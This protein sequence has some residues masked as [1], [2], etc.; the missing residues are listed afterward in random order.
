MQEFYIAREG[1]AYGP[2]TFDDTNR[3]FLEGSIDRETLVWEPSESNWIFAENH[4]S[5]S[6]IF[7]RNVFPEN[8]V[9]SQVIVISNQGEIEKKANE[10]AIEEEKISEIRKEIELLEC[11]HKEMSS[12][13]EDLRI[14]SAQ[15]NTELD[16]LVKKRNELSSELEE[17][18]REIEKNR[19]ELSK[20]KPLMEELESIRSEKKNLEEDISKTSKELE[21]KLIECAGC[22]AEISLVRDRLEAI[23]SETKELEARRIE[24]EAILGRQVSEGFE[25]IKNSCSEFDRITGKWNEAGERDEELRKTGLSAISELRETLA[26]R[27][28]ELNGMIASLREQSIGEIEYQSLKRQADEEEKRLERF[29]DE[30]KNLT[31]LCFEESQRLEDYKKEREEVKTDIDAEFTR[32][33]ELELNLKQLQ[34][35]AETV[36]GSLGRL[37]FE[38][39]QLET[40]VSALKKEKEICEE[41]VEELRRARSEIIESNLKIESEVSVS[42]SRKAELE[43]TIL[44]YELALDSVVKKIEAMK[45]EREAMRIA[46][47][48]DAIKAR[49]FTAENDTMRKAAIEA[50]KEVELELDSSFEELARM[51]DELEKLQSENSRLKEELNSS[52]IE[53]AR[54]TEERKIEEERF[55]S[56]QKRKTELIKE[57]DLL[58]SELD[59]IRGETASLNENVISLNAKKAGLEERISALEKDE[60]L[61]QTGIA[62]ME[63][64]IKSLDSAR[65][66]LEKERA[67]LARVE[68]RELRELLIA[69]EQDEKDKLEKLLNEARTEFRLLKE[70]WSKEERLGVTNEELKQLRDEVEQKRSELVKAERQLSA[71]RAGLSKLREENGKNLLRRVQSFETQQLDDIKKRLSE[72]R[73]EMESMENEWTDEMK[74]TELVEKQWIEI[75]SALHDK[76]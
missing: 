11:E 71:M 20:M 40:E 41:T 43:R 46:L 58:L 45:A 23:R 7:S 69:R 30:L 15:L 59:S 60:M 8:Q 64:K 9:Q 70:E 3:M 4:P 72:T 24:A 16:N 26:K 2:L 12:K 65:V 55:S 27:E 14:E 39:S 29:R 19:D 33:G 6:Q 22:D 74:G 53:L 49:E 34:K 66:S 63:N 25:R 32:Y 10:L 57:K 13:R 42:L 36:S 68:L 48:D 28:S 75:Q 67:K 37:T 52:A 54:L 21:Q 73:G 76:I 44:D 1:V 35:D 47:E 38:Y 5:I 50:R 18:R 51:K 62:E 31:A 17:S 56:I 61:C